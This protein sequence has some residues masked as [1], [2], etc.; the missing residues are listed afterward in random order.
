MVR[1]EIFGRNYFGGKVAYAAAKKIKA[2]NQKGN[3][4]KHF[5]LQIPK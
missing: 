5:F 4:T 3:N 2:C 1:H